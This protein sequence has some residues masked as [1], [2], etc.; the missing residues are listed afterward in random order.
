MRKVGEL[1]FVIPFFVL[2][3]GG[4]QK[5]RDRLF[6]FIAIDEVDGFF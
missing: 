4:G 2:E 6:V 1:L 3:F 5:N